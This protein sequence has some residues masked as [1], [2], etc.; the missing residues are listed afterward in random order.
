MLEA[1]GNAHKAK[2][3]ERRKRE[4]KADEPAPESGLTPAFIEGEPERLRE[5][6][7]DTR[8]RAEHDAANN[9]IME[10]GDQERAVV[11]HEIDRRYRQQHAGQAAHD[12]SNHE[13]DKP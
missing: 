2:R 7:G 10:M 4:P 6:I 1:R 12:E 3:V 5:P 11:K 8:Q 13:A 9:D